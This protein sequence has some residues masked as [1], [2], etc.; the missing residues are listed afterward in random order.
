[1]SPRSRSTGLVS[2]NLTPLL[3]VVLQLITF[4]MMLVHFGTRLEGANRAIRLPVAPA[5]LPGSD[6]TIDRL[7]VSLDARGGLRVGTQVLSGDAATAWWAAQ[8][9]LR[10]AGLELLPSDV[11]AGAQGE[12]LEGRRAAVESSE[13]PGFDELPT[14]VILRADR[15]ASYGAVRRTLTEAQ[16]QG[17]ARFSLVVL[18]SEPR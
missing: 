9:K 8:A 6:L 2:P 16:E 13:G 7:P 3:D 10:R 14:V 4:F 17:F 15:E 1:M 11:A 18:R 5:A 12:A